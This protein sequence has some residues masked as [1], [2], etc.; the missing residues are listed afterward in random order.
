MR[1]FANGVI[2]SKLETRNEK[3]ETKNFELQILNS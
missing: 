1:K 3:L 2:N